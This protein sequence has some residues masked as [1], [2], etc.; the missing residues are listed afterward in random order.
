MQFCKNVKK[1]FNCI[2]EK[3]CPSQSIKEGCLPHSPTQDGKGL[4]ADN[5]GESTLKPVSALRMKASTIIWVQVLG[6][7][8]HDSAYG[9]SK[10]QLSVMY[11]SHPREDKPQKGREES[12]AG[13]EV[14][15]FSKD[16]KFSSPGGRSLKWDGNQQSVSPSVATGWILSETN[17]GKKGVHTVH[18]RSPQPVL[19]CGLLGTGRAAGELGKLHLYWQ[20]LPIAHGTAELHPVSAQWQ[21]QILIAP[22]ILLCTALSRDLGCILHPSSRS[23]SP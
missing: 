9:D 4:R 13:G 7:H 20:P 10:L 2:S 1:F 17:R 22:Q 18:S 15:A 11:V 16:S 12:A 6:R 5:I 3:H 19:V 23:P 21:H 8:C 14:R